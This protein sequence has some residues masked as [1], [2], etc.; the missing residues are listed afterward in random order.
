VLA[1]ATASIAR[2]LAD[3]WR[4]SIVPKLVYALVLSGGATIATAAFACSPQT[5]LLEQ[6]VILEWNH[7]FQQLWVVDAQETHRM[8]LPNGSNLGL[9]SEP[10][11]ASVHSR[12]I[13]DAQFTA[14]LVKITLYDMAGSSPKVL[15][16]TMLIRL[17]P[18]KK[19]IEQQQ[20]IYRKG[21]KGQRRFAMQNMAIQL[22]SLR[23]P[24]A[25]FVV[26]NCFCVSW[27]LTG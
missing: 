14:E 5:G 17:T 10:A 16:H 9:R 22:A 7:Q 19:Q 18:T 12:A 1:G 11:D 4:G 8:A 26:K 25:S 21:H 27:V 20:T 3:L 15:V 2:Q 24:F 6:S 23:F 13:G